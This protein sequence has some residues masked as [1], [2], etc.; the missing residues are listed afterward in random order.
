MLKSKKY[1]ST[2]I[3]LTSLLLLFTTHT[4]A[5]SLNSVNVENNNVDSNS[6]STNSVSNATLPNESDLSL[7]TNPAAN[8]QSLDRIDYTTSSFDF[9]NI[10]NILLI[11]VGLVII[12]LAVAILI[13]LRK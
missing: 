1:F 4:F 12:L 3:I 2:F 13:R 7:D 5:S 6:V 11:A 8:V 10:I 9:S